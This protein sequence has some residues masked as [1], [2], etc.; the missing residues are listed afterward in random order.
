MKSKIEI[1]KGVHPGLVIENRLKKLNIQKGRFALSIREHPQ[2]LSAII[3]GKRSMNLPLSLKIEKA[4]GYDDGFL[5]TLQIYYDIVRIRKEEDTAL[6]REP[7]KL[8]RILFWDT[9]PENIHWQM[10]KGYIIRRILER[11]SDTDKD[12]IV[13]YYGQEVV[14]KYKGEPDARQLLRYKK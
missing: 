9:T 12:R 2:T 4:L 14:D 13:E 10:H 5:M 6:Y 1:I 11:G 7:P 3:S 8:N